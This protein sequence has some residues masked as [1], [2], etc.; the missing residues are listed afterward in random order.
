MFNFP[1]KINIFIICGVIYTAGLNFSKS[2]KV[3]NHSI[4]VVWPFAYPTS[5]PKKNY[6]F[7]C[8]CRY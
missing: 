2:N 5:T 6:L 7:V 4:Y 1:G 8:G 3:K